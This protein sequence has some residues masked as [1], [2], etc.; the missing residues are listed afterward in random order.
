MKKILFAAVACLLL[1]PALTFAQS[2]KPVKLTLWSEGSGPKK[3]LQ[4]KLANQFMEENPNV[5]ITL[6]WMAHI[7]LDKKLPTAI[8]TGAAPDIWSLSYRLVSSYQSNLAPLTDADARAMGYKSVKD[9]EGSW[10]PGAL[11]QYSI[12]PKHYALMWEYNLFGWAINTD[13]FKAAGLNPVNDAPK[14]WDDVIRLGKKLVIKEG[15]RIKRQAVTFPYG[16]PSIWYFMEIQPMINELGGSVMNAAGTE[17][18][19]NS[20]QAVRAVTEVKRRFD[21]GITDRALSS[22]TEYMQLCQQGEAS[23][24]IANVVEWPTWYGIVNPALKGKIRAI[25]N[26]TFPGKES[27][28]GVSSWGY[29]V[30]VNCKDKPWAWKFIDYLVKD[31]ALY[32]KETGGLIPRKGWAQTDA[33]K[34]IPDPAL[35]ARM[36]Q[37]TYPSGL[38]K[39]WAEISEPIKTAMQ[40]ILFEDKDIHETLNAVKVTVDNAIQ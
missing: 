3:E 9:Y 7:D 11:E 21:E 32:L 20:E 1:T 8:A 18:L 22:T 33:A 2:Q 40:S 25:A 16:S 38:L 36:Q 4:I 19:I 15:G 29:A 37:A 26:P 17:C 31:P 23:M 12:G 10:E 39:N 13:H 28:C 30:N 14:Y 35:I 6:E 27:R 34:L 24:F 5:S